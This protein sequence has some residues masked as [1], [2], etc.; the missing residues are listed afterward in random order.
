MHRIPC[1][2]VITRSLDPDLVDEFR[3]CTAHLHVLHLR[4]LAAQ[5]QL[6]DAM[7]RVFGVEFCEQLR[8]QLFDPFRGAALLTQRRHGI[9]RLAIP[10][11]MADQES[12][13]AR[14]VCGIGCLLGR[15]YSHWNRGSAVFRNQLRTEDAVTKQNRRPNLPDPLHT[16]TLCPMN[17]GEDF[18][19]FGCVRRNNCVGGSSELLHL[20]DWNHRDLLEYTTAWETF[21]MRFGDPAFHGQLVQR[22]VFSRAAGVERIC[23]SP[24]NVL[25]S[26]KRQKSWLD[27]MRESLLRA[28]RTFSK[29]L[30]PGWILVFDNKRWLH[31]RSPIQLL[32]GVDRL[33]LA[34]HVSR[35]TTTL[36]DNQ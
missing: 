16:D 26:N 12:S 14:L 1:E 7:Y 32:P 10:E 19:V 30:E 36:N 8:K 22:P 17:L 20:D 15:P 13:V 3:R 23:W 35:A 34:A 2:R 29:A 21:L 33:L 24:R 6:R 5:T 11:A 27:A 4:E 31:G 18:A 25:P 9:E 28:P